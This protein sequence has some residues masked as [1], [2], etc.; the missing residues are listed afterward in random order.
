MV[1]VPT[2]WLQE[3][4]PSLMVSFRPSCSWSDCVQGRPGSGH[5]H[6]LKLTYSVIAPLPSPV[7]DSIIII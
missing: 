3:V 4:A 7:A 2:D 6:N 5:P 1:R